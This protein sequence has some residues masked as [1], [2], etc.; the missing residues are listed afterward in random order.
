MHQYG[1]QGDGGDG[2]PPC[3]QIHVR[4][5]VGLREAQETG[6]KNQ[7]KNNHKLTKNQQ[8]NTARDC[9]SEHNK[10]WTHKV[11]NEEADQTL[12]EGV[13]HVHPEHVWL[14][15]LRRNTQ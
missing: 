6:W 12:V 5:S 1:E 14:V 11:R 9:G 2:S 4:V 15:F 13:D 8:K 7:K 10:N 3:K